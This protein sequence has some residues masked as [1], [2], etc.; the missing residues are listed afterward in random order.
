MW[1]A[2][3][4]PFCHALYVN[5]SR[6]SDAI[7]AIIG[8]DNGLLADGIKTM[9]DKMLT[10]PQGDSVAVTAELFNTTGNYSFDIIA[11]FPRGQKLNLISVTHLRSW[12]S[13][14]NSHLMDLIQLAW[15]ISPSE[16]LLLWTLRRVKVETPDSEQIQGNRVKL[17]QLISTVVIATHTLNTLHEISRIP[18][19]FKYSVLNLIKPAIDWEDNSCILFPWRSSSTKLLKFWK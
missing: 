6:P 14:I 9:P 12:L 13:P 7:S 4:R 18:F 2:V 11:T 16:I 8:S 3:W 5:S 15:S 17:L 19:E 1:S 10:S